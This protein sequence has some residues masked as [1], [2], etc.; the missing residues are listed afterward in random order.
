LGEVAIIQVFDPLTIR[1]LCFTLVSSFI[2][3][4]HFAEAP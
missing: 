4:R 1:P 2:S 3:E